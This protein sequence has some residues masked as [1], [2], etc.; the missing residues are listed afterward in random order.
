MRAAGC[1]RVFINGSFVTAKVAPGDYDGCWDSYGVAKDQVDP[2]LLDLQ[3]GR[4]AQKLKYY[5]ELF[6]ADFVEGGGGK[7]FLEFSQIDKN[8]GQTKGIIEL[9]L[10]EVP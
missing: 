2:I 8:T 6:P 3:D 10:R 5:G 1:R 4:I 9:N 7:T